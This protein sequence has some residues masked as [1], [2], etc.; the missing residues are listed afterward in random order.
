MDTKG[1]LNRIMSGSLVLQIAVGIA[2]GVI[3]SL[4]SQD[5]ARASMILLGRPS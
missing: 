2:A 3:L 4:V 5:A 1:L